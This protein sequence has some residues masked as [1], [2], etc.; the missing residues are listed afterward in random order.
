MAKEKRPAMPLYCRDV[1]ADQFYIVMSLAERGAYMTLLMHCW[2]DRFI[3][4]DSA[5][6]AKLV[7]CS[8]EEMGAAW[9]VIRKRFRKAKKAGYLMHK[10]VEEVRSACGIRQMR[11]VRAAEIG[12]RK[13]WDSNKIHDNR[14]FQTSLS[15]SSSSSSSSSRREENSRTPLSEKQYDPN[16]GW[17][18]FEQEYPGELIPDRDC[19]VWL[20]VITTQADEETLWRNLPVWKLSRKWQDG[21]IPS[22]QNFLFDG[23]WKVAPKADVARARKSH[24]DEI[25]EGI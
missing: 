8:E 11:R 4:D 7:G 12:A 21:F 3:P 5:K 13:R 17:L 24:L 15:S 1:L 18:R 10:R 2:M 25:M 22:A 6:C 9:S 19:R 23:H 16:P 20:S 14:M